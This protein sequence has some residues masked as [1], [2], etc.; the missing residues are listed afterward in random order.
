M[1]SPAYHIYYSSLHI[2]GTHEPIISRNCSI[3]ATLLFVTLYGWFLF[4]WM[5]WT[6]T[7]SPGVTHREWQNPVSHRFCNF[8]RWWAHG[9]PKHVERSNKYTKYNCASSWIYLQDFTRMRGQQNIKLKNITSARKFS[10]RYR[11][12]R[13]AVFCPCCLRR[14]WPTI[15][16]H[17][18]SVS[19]TALSATCFSLSHCSLILGR[20]MWLCMFFF[21]VSSHD[22]FAICSQWIRGKQNSKLHNLSLLWKWNVLPKWFKRK[23]NISW[24]Q[25]HDIKYQAQMQTTSLKARTVVGTWH[26]QVHSKDGAY[27]SLH[28]LHTK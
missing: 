25:P 21:C 27:F 7:S 24:T 4:R 6:A 22:H 13:W 5:E 3:Y 12:C 17:S 2:S 28:A 10:H 11:G 18:F 9:C 26:L 8:S 14:S 1:H 23:Q 16:Q 20:W 15:N 19:L